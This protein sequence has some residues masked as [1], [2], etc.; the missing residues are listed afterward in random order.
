MKWW[1]YVHSADNSIHLKRW[2]PVPFGQLCDLEYAKQEK[3][4]GNDFILAIVDEPFEA[5][6]RD[7]A[8]VK[9]QEIF[10]KMGLLDE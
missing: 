3:S 8:L 5:D 1:A 6:S 7:E 10:I 2:F 9:A 4:Q